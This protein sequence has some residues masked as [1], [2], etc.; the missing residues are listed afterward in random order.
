M[1][2]KQG[3]TYK[4]DKSLIN[5]KMSYTH[6]RLLRMELPHNQIFSMQKLQ[7]GLVLLIILRLALLKEIQI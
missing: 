6:K 7:A 2:R 4:K 1:F 3:N 5:A